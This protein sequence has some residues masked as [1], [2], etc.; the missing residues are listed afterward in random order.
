MS[1]RGRVGG[2]VAPLLRFWVRP[3][4]TGFSRRRRRQIVRHRLADPGQT[5]LDTESVFTYPG[6]MN[7]TIAVEDDLLEEAR[8]LARRR[9]V[10]LQELLREHLRT[11]VGERSGA[12]VADELLELMKSHGG[13]SGGRRWRREDAYEGRA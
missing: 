13:H 11:L 6:S 4:G 9:G 7:L 8:N 1:F 10:S 12:E 3:R 5:A 2:M